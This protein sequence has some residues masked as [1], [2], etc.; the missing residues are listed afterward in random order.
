MGCNGR[1]APLAGASGSFYARQMQAS[2][3]KLFQLLPQ[4]GE[5]LASSPFQQLREQYGRELTMAALRGVLDTLRAE[6]RAGE[7]DEP[8]LEHELEALPL[9]VAA[10]LAR[11]AEPTL[12]RVLNATGVILQTNLGRAPLSPEALHHLVEV[13]GS[14]SNLEYD[15]VSGARSRRDVHV[16]ETIL[17]LLRQRTSLPLDH[18]AAAVVNNCAAATLLA[19]N[20]LAEGGEVI[21]SR[22]ELVEIGGGF[23]VPEILMK[24]GAMLREVG[25]TNRTRIADYSGA[26]GAGTRLILRVHRSNFSIEGFAEQP[27]RAELVALGR[28]RGVPVFEDQGTGAIVDLAEFGVT[29]ESSWTASLASGM[30]LVASSGDKLLGGP[31]SGLLVGERALVERVRANP[32][33]RALRVDKLTYAALDATLRQY[34]AG[35]EAAVPVIAAM[36]ASQESLRDRSER[37]RE[38]LGGARTVEATVV[39]TESVI[40]GGTTPGATLPSYAVALRPLEGGEDAL[41][42]ALRQ[43]A[44]PVIGRVQDGSVLLDLRTIAPGDDEELRNLLVAAIQPC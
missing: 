13:A 16:Q 31:Q 25:T 11:D 17:A 6:L 3:P 4:I 33:F 32:L 9:T 28:A 37:L 38:A 10:A 41:A 26:I 8:W 19:L 29:A 36:R 5:L 39:A 44:T 43:L 22:G 2:A 20:T 34:L 14:Y 35:K 12:R 27:T 15:L 21:V 24:S 30:Q 42:R 18:H 40:G 1:G 23:R 7:H